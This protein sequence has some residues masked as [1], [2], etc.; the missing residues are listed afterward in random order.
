MRLTRR[1]I[2]QSGAAA[3]A[4][5]AVTGL[6][7]VSPAQA[8]PAA[9][10]HTWKHGLSLFGELKYPDSFKRFDYVNADAPKGGVARLVA[11][12]TF[13]NFNQVVSGV[14]GSIA[15]G[16]DQIYD[17]LMV[18]ALDEVSTEYGLLAEAV[19]HPADFSSVTYRL[20][21][22]AKWH[23]G[24]PVTVEDVIF[25]LE[26]FKKNHPQWS[27]Y[28]S[29]VTKAE[30]TGE[31]E[32]TFTFDGPGNRELPQI[33]G[34]LTVL[35]KHWWEGTDR[36]GKKRDVAATTL[37][38]PLGC[39]AYRIK[40]FVAG[41]TIAYE[42]VP[43]YWGK[44][45][46]VNIGRDNFNEL[47]YEYFRDPTVALEAF[48]ADAIDWRTE[49][50]AKNWATAYDFPAVKDKRV[51]LEEFP[52]NSSGVMQG[53]AFNIRRA[54]VPGLAGAPRVQLRV[55][56]RGNEPA[57]FLR[58]VQAHREL[59]RRPGACGARP[60]RGRGARDPRNRARQGAGRSVHQALHQSG[61]RQPR[62]HP[63]QSARRRA[64][65]ARGRL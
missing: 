17:T 42:R 10:P 5:P 58:P 22:N 44:D 50:S 49:N 21:A 43:D 36:S 53:F 59:L 20:R 4:A 61:R 3:L 34:Q 33:V 47:R 18:A 48:K 55:R 56:F 15:A 39:G 19:S 64:S 65:L 11:F 27:A 32:V 63:R 46:N 41:R 57:D 14:K 23:D 6:P 31:R 7:A 2:L 40:E 35:P 16:I 37:E 29:H 54:Q 12:G 13:D 38:P 24:K 1:A 26:A 25:S 30:K 52:N 9:T 8:Q 60:A 45:L 51:V 28:Y 62:E